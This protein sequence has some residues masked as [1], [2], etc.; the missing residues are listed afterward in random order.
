M[1]KILFLALGFPNVSKANNLYTDLMEEFAQRGHD[2]LV[3]APE[4]NDNGHGINF[5][6]QVKVLRVKTLPLFN[7][8]TI[9]KGVANV[10]LPFQYRSAIK[11]HCQDL[12]F[13][14]IVLPTPPITLLSVASWLKKKSS[15]KVY[16][17]LRDIFPQNAVDLG[18]MGEHGLFHRLFRKQEKDLYKLSDA[19]GC[20]SQANVD[21]VKKHNPELDFAKLHL[22]PNWERLPEPVS[23]EDIISIREKYGLQDKFVVVFGG[24]MGRP[25]KME[26][27]VELANAC[28]D[29][30]RICFYLIGSGTEK[31]RVEQMIEGLGL[32]NIKTIDQL[33]KKEYIQI[34]AASDVGLISLSDEFT[35]P[36]FPSKVLTYFG[37]KKPVLASLDLSTDFGQMLQETRSGLWSEAGKIDEF[38]KNLLWFLE[39]SEE[40]KVMGENGYNYMK[41]D[42]TPEIAHDTIVEKIR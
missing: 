4:G 25:Q 15:A 24:N 34:L 13:D 33:P 32:Q 12:D 7:V 3:V 2:V 38:K 23:K 1:K 37:L 36:N 42:L 18:M 16:L 9:K 29:N 19:I 5:E 35:I 11:K 31:H 10:L 6:G 20:M 21:Y 14:L 17:I 40:S 41:T 30:E 8:G 39:H 27:I 22:L 28:K 26:N